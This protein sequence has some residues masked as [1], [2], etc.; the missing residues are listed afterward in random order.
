MTKENESIVHRE[1]VKEQLS[2]LGM[3]VFFSDEEVKKDSKGRVIDT[4]PIKK[5]A[6]KVVKSTT[7]K[8][9]TKTSRV[10]QRQRV[11]K[12]ASP[13]GAK[14]LSFVENILN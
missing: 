2:R 13:T 3:D 7:P 11:Q 12:S 9:V 6:K 4:N 8:K 14:F 5:R 10:P 1:G